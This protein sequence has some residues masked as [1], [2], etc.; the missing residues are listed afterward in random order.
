MYAQM[1]KSKEKKNGA[2]TSSAVTQMESRERTGLKL[3]DN[4]MKF[5]SNDTRMRFSNIPHLHQYEPK[6]Q[7]LSAKVAITSNGLKIDRDD[8]KNQ[9]IKREG[10]EIENDKKMTENIYGEKENTYRHVTPKAA[11]IAVPK[12]I[13]EEKFASDP[14]VAEAANFLKSLQ[15]SMDS[16]ERMVETEDSAFMGDEKSNSLMNNAGNIDDYSSIYA[17]MKKNGAGFENNITRDVTAVTRA[18]VNERMLN[19]QVMQDSK[20]YPGQGEN[21][22]YQER[23]NLVKRIG[24]E[25]NV[26]FAVFTRLQMTGH[27]NFEIYKKNIGNM[28]GLDGYIE[29]CENIFLEAVKSK[30][31]ETEIVKQIAGQEVERY[32]KLYHNDV[33][34]G[35]R[36]KNNSIPRNMTSEPKNKLS[37]E[38]K[39]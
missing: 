35:K 10:M 28:D 1:N 7:Q 34:F 16:W 38:F 32:L 9:E 36:N 33:W 17:L 20:L 8:N 29:K 30:V 11:R 39:K 3:T 5:G 14:V 19:F 12:S 24:N 15:H 27:L 37:S 26:A 13:F 2:G 21:I 31:Y 25:K 4:R 23:E 18:V 6:V 22:S